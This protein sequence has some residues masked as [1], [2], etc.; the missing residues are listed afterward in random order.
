MSHG[1]TVMSILLRISFLTKKLVTNY[2]DK[3]NV[4]EA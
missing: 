4:G 1:L 3:P 2:Y